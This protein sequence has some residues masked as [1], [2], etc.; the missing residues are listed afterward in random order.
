MWFSEGGIYVY[1]SFNNLYYYVYLQ[2]G[3]HKMFEVSE[4][5][6][7]Q[8]PIKMIRLNPHKTY[9]SCVSQYTML[10]YTKHMLCLYMYK[11]FY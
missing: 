5:Q 6:A 10:I 9:T 11:P 2:R 8:N 3:E 4:L 1:V 7:I